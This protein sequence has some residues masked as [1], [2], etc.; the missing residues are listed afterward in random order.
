MLALG[1]RFLERRNSPRYA[2]SK[3]AKILFRNR[4]CKMNCAVVEISN[5]GARLHPS[6]AG[7]LP[8]EFELVLAPNQQL[9]CEAVHRTA[10]E[11]G[12]RF[13]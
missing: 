5:T 8:N 12:V 3:N 6:D 4:S 9:K 2:V 13:L 1:R 11:I 7:L 10:E